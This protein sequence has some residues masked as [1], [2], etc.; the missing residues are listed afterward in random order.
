VGST[1]RRLVV[2]GSLGIKQ[3]PVFKITQ[4]K[5]AESMTQVVECLPGKHKAPTSIPVP[6]NKYMINNKYGG[7][8]FKQDH[9]TVPFM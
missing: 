2:Q 1:S 3:D 7:I 9:I 6:Q 8:I 5:Q 4:A